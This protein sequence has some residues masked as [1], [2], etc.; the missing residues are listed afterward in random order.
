MTPAFRN[1][2]EHSGNLES[3]MP[4]PR[5]PII[6]LWPAL[7]KN[8]LMPASGAHEAGSVSFWLMRPSPGAG[9]SP[10]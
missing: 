9:F 8:P 2:S 7:P 3:I 5:N 6:Q 10:A 1:L 4:L